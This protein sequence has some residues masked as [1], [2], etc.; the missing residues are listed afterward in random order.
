VVLTVTTP[1]ALPLRL[2]ALGWVEST[3]QDNPEGSAP[4][5]TVQLLRIPLPPVVFIAARRL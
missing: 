5:T 1:T 4:D 2:Q 3:D